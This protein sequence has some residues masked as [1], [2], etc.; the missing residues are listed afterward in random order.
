MSSYKIKIRTANLRVENQKVKQ[1]TLDSLQ[2]SLQLN[3]YSYMKH[4]S[5]VNK[6]RKDLGRTFYDQ[7]LEFTCTD[8][9]TQKQLRNFIKKLR[10]KGF[11]N[12]N[13]P[14]LIDF[15]D[16]TS[17]DIL[18][19]FSLD[20]TPVEVKKKSRQHANRS[21]YYQRIIWKKP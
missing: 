4:L 20:G 21:S 12:N 16:T 7:W 11:T 14:I 10:N 15:V 1:T 17:N 18:Y 8:K 6:V 19:R 5:I 13:I 3:S 9:L 2:S